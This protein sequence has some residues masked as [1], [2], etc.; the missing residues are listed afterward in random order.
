[1][2][3]RMYV[4][5]LNTFILNKK[6]FQATKPVLT[7][8][9]I[10]CHSDVSITLL[11]VWKGKGNLEISLSNLIWSKNNSF[12]GICLITKMIKQPLKVK[13]ATITSNCNKHLPVAELLA[14]SNENN[15][16]YIHILSITQDPKIFITNGLWSTA[17]LPKTRAIFLLGHSTSMSVW[18]QSVPKPVS[19]TNLP[20]K[21]YNQRKEWMLLGV[22]AKPKR[23]YNFW[24]VLWT[25]GI[26]IY[27][28]MVV[29]IVIG[30]YSLGFSL[31]M[32]SMLVLMICNSSCGRSDMRIFTGWY[33][34]YDTKCILLW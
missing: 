29:L 8:F 13:R 5:C 14:V 11:L 34:Q 10:F 3:V 19:V 12:T 25:V 22:S 7:Y 27:L 23:A 20:A 33:L 2:Y 31:T 26:K 30:Q 21:V 6:Y 17:L 18:C 16:D 9:L 15:N 28:Q 1:M 24:N 32:S 4:Y